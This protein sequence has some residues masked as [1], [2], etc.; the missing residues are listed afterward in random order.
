MK[1]SLVLS[2]LCTAWCTTLAPAAS[3]T[4]RRPNIIY[5]MADDMGF[6]DLGCHGQEAI[7]TPHVDRLAVEGRQFTQCY[8]GSTVCAPSRSALMTGLHTGHTRVRSNFGMVG[9][10]GPQRRVPLRDED[11]TVAEVLKRAGYATGITGKWGLGEPESSGV[12]NKQGFDEWFGYLNQRRAHSYYPDYI[13]KNQEKYVLKGNLDGRRQQYTHDLFTEFALDFIERQSAGPFFLYLAY[14]V[15]HGKHEVPSDAPYSDKDWPEKLKNYAAMV[16]RLD[17]DV[18]RIMAMLE[19]LDVDRH[20]IVFF[21][22]D[23]GAAFVDPTFKS[24]GS[25]RGKKG[26]F[27]EG[28]IRVPMIVRWPGHIEPGSTSDQVWAFWDFLPTAAELAGLEPPQNIDG[29]S[30][31]PALLGKKQHGHE[32]LYWEISSGGYQQA[33]RHGRWKAVRNR[34][35]GPLEL[36]DLDADPGET[37]DVV[38]EHP[39]V[40]ARIEAYLKTARTESENW[41]TP[42]K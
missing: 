15:P 39:R 37:R 29:I 28:G 3:E 14:T 41:P 42:K 17:R 40:V 4:S 18:G 11:L 33:V 26:N 12:P 27:Y 22:S 13:W 20:T 1:P 35:S 36:Y 5:I 10:V 32:F 6:A 23:N 30:M 16:T 9:G 34:W 38:K 31:L 21:T 19:K 7:R 25:L 8:A 24:T 2:L